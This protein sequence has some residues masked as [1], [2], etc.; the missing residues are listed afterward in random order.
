[1]DTAGTTISP[2]TQTDRW[3]ECAHGL[4]HDPSIMN[5]DLVEIAAGPL[6]PMRPRWQSKLIPVPI[7]GGK[8]CGD[9]QNRW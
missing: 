9:Y 3:I 7:R 8:Q 1:M 2:S 4:P 6:T 5:T